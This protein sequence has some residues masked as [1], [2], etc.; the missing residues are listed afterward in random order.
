MC[1]CGDFPGD[2]CG[3]GD[4]CACPCACPCARTRDAVGADGF[5]FDAPDPDPDGHVGMYGAHDARDARF[6][7]SEIVSASASTSASMSESGVVYFAEENGN[8]Q[9]SVTVTVTVTGRDNV[10]SCVWG[11]GVV[12]LRTRTLT[13]FTTGERASPF[14]LCRC[15][16]ALT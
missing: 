12:R 2:R 7:V 9:E 10:D 4:E 5:G 14:V 16:D 3:C 1:V 11:N 8:Q 13:L 6:H 15:D